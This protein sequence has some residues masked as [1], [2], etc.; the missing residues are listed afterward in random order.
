MFVAE[1]IELF[2][3]SLLLITK[4]AKK[5]FKT[6]RYG[7]LNLPR[8]IRPLKSTEWQMWKNFKA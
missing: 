8:N 4:K 5:R 2:F 1:I 3:R 6:L 7:H